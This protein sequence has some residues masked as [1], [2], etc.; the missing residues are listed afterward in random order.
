MTFYDI[1]ENG[2]PRENE[3]YFNVLVIC[4]A[5]IPQLA[6]ELLGENVDEI[7]YL[8]QITSTRPT[9]YHFYIEPELGIQYDETEEEEYREEV[10]YEIC[11]FPHSV[12]EISP[13]GE[14]SFFEMLDFDTEDFWRI[15]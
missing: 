15:D 4:I 6:K 7:Y 8:D 9:V 5:V 12:V 11:L 13:Q 3:Y 1:P 10:V 2:L 14:I